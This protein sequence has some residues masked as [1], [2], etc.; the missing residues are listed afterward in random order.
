MSE[1]IEIVELA[2]MSPIEYGKVRKAQAKIHDCGGVKFLD[3]SVYAEQRKQRVIDFEQA[4]AKKAADQQ[5]AE[6]LGKFRL[7][8]NWLRASSYATRLRF[9]EMS[10]YTEILN[11]ERWRALDDSDILEIYE[12]AHEEGN[13]WSRDMIQ[14]AVVRTAQLELNRVH[15]L[16]DYLDGLEWDGRPRIDEWL[17][18]YLGAESCPHSSA[19]GAK[20]LISAVARVFQP[21][22]KADH[23]LVLE[24]K[25]GIGKST[26][27][28]ILAGEWFADD[29]PDIRSK[30]AKQ[31][32]A[33]HWIIEIAELAALLKIDVEF[34]RGFISTKIDIYRASYGRNTKR[35]PRQCIFAGTTN[36]DE[37]LTDTAGNR[38]FWPVATGEIDLMQLRLD[39]N[40]LWAEAVYRY[41]QGEQ[42]WLE[43]DLEA[44]AADEAGKRQQVDV[45]QDKIEDFLTGKTAVTVPQILEQCL[46]IFSSKQTHDH[47]TRIG[48]CLAMAGWVKH[49]ARRKGSE[50]RGHYYVPKK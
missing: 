9:N 28:N 10:D 40:D 13:Q 21:G 17:A 4:K 11:G 32:L 5:G 45:W 1:K 6:S 25:Q 30:D 26:A 3:A 12:A 36:S 27:L 50:K 20:W 37:Y 33:G 24:G 44:V 23:M 42:W 49:R 15:L 47:R 35:H 48:K 46:C 34:I 39:R 19:V 43:P 22:C 38:R 31:Y 29:L 2:K 18:D 7:C 16:R 41:K 14:D 8:C